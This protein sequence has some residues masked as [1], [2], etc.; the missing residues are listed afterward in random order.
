MINVQPARL[1]DTVDLP[2]LASERRG[3][4][5][6]FRRR[7]GNTNR[8]ERYFPARDCGFSMKKTA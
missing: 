7:F 4:F 6:R 1:S 3:L 2:V 5:N 8:P